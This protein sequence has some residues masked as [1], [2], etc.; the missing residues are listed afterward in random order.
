[1][2]DITKMCDE[3]EDCRKRRNCYSNG[4]ICAKSIVYRYIDGDNNKLLKLKAEINL[5]KDTEKDYQHYFSILVSTIALLLAILSNLKSVYYAGYAV[6]SVAVIAGL[7]IIEN[8]YSKK[9]YMRKKLIRYMEVVI[10]ELE[11][12]K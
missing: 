8:Y 11:N 3:I 12:K 6:F 4:V 5:H 9:T 7:I 2:N 10:E 1:M